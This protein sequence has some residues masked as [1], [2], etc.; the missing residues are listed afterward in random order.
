MLVGLP[1]GA[2]LITNGDNDTF[3]PLTLQAGMAMRPDV[4]VV[5][6]HLL[7]LED[8]TDALFEQYPS[9]KPQG[10]FQPD[11]DLS[12]SNT[13]LKRMIEDP[14][15]KVYFAPSVATHQLGFEPELT[16][17]GINLRSTKDGLSAEESARLFLDTYRLD[18]ATDWTIAWDLTP[19]LGRMMINSVTGMVRIA[20]ND[21]LSAATKRELID[22]AMEIAEFHDMT[23]LINILGKLEDT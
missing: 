21:E 14:D 23:R 15:I 9:I 6:R 19:S 1:E 5:N 18:S 2:V 16:V 12:M 3:P 20:M 22:K 4:A 10:E 8:F 11:G 7:N 17:E 13:L